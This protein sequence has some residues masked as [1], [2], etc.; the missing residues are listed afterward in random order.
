MLY[1]FISL[2][3]LFNIRTVNIIIIMS[4]YDEVVK[5]YFAFLI[6][7][8]KLQ[9]RREFPF[10]RNKRVEWN[11]SSLPSVWYEKNTRA[12]SVSNEISKVL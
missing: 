4:Y 11:I 8:Q 12:T 7:I 6:V 1:Y 9:Q 3:T 10:W 2:I 5:A